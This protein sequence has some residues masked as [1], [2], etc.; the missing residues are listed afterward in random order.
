MGIAAQQ[1]F[2]PCAAY[3]RTARCGIGGGLL[4]LPRGT[5]VHEHLPKELLAQSAQTDL[6]IGR[7][8]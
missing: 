7:E 1:A 6:R 4:V 3:F 5:S 2:L 8:R